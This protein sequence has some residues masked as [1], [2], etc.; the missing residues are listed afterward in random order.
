MTDAALSAKGNQGAHVYRVD[1]SWA[2]S[3]GAGYDSYERHHRWWVLSADGS[4][5]VTID[6]M[7]SNDPAFG[8]D[9]TLV[10]PEQLVVAAAASCQLFS[11]LAV[12]ARARTDVIAYE[13]AAIGTMSH[14]EGPMALDHIE[15]HPTITLRPTP[16]GKPADDRLDHLVEVAHRSCFIANSLRTEVSVHPTY[17]RA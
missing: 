3:T 1:I 16:D 4:D 17:V 9:P 12:V 6:D 2:G 14:V 11:F 5:E 7:M 8:G 13:D 10:N 15:L